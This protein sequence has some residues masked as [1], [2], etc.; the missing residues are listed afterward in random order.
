M[1]VQPDEYEYINPT[2]E[3]RKRLLVVWA[4][5]LALVVIYQVVV[6]LLFFHSTFSWLVPLEPS[7][8]CAFIDECWASPNRALL[9]YSVAIIPFF[10]IEGIRRLKFALS[11]LSLRTSPPTK[12][13]V[14]FRT[15]LRKGNVAVLLGAWD[16]LLALVLLGGSIWVMRYLILVLF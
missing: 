9:F 16:V 4:S 11:V 13:D 14:F 7:A 3:G 6:W 10:F 15:K 2:S 1:V 8:D 12:K 5:I